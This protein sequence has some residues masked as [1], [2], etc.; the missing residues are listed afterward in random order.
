MHGRNHNYIELVFNKKID[1]DRC[2]IS[3]ATSIFVYNMFWEN[4][5]TYLSS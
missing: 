3:S 5:G 2:S 1:D 4:N